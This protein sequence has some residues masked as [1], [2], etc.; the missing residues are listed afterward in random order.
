MPYGLNNGLLL[1][2]PGACGGCLAEPV[3]VLCLADLGD[4]FGLALPK[5]RPHPE[6]GPLSQGPG[7][8][9]QKRGPLGS[10]SVSASRANAIR[11]KVTLP[12]LC[13]AMLRVRASWSSSRA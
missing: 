4:Q 10:P 2:E 12:V 1:A 9:S 7:R 5:H 11:H 3:R 13:A 6:A 8:A